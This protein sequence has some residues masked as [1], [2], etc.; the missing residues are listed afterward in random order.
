[1]RN[2]QVMWLDVLSVGQNHL[3][4]MHTMIDVCLLYLYAIL[5]AFISIIFLLAGHDEF[6]SWFANNDG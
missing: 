3:L 1:M 5:H 2:N 6:G 4:L